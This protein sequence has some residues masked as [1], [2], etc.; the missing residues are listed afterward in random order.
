MN[1]NAI[2][3]GCGILILG[4]A[5]FFVFNRGDEP[6]VSNEIPS[7]EIAKTAV[8]TQ[9]VLPKNAPRLSDTMRAY[10]S[11]IESTVDTPRERRRGGRRGRGMERVQLTPEQRAVIQKGTA[12]AMMGQ[13]AVQK[14]LVAMFDANGDGIIDE[15]ERGEVRNF[16]QQQVQEMRALMTGRFG[17]EDLRNMSDEDRQKAADDA[18][19]M[20]SLYVDETYTKF[21]TDGNGE[22]NDTEE[23]AFAQ[24][25][26]ERFRK[27]ETLSSAVSDVMKRADLEKER[28]EMKL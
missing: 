26:L 25:L 10:T 5:V 24:D 12:I 15:A 27:G 2:V 3:I 7:A 1:K 13:R 18:F 11:E 6:P 16:M 28:A 19:R 21:D 14:N 23:N 9:L 22:F 20:V 8:D 17:T 4:A